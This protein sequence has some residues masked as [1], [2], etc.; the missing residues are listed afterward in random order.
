MP[1]IVAVLG[2]TS[3]G[4]YALSALAQSSAQNLPNVEVQ[5]KRPKPARA[6]K[7]P[8]A[9]PVEEA[10]EHAHR[11]AEPPLSAAPASSTT[12]GSQT[13]EA[14]KPV[15]ND[16]ATL[17]AN[18]PGV[19][20]YQSGG[21][22]SLP[23]IHGLADDRVRTELNGMLITSACGNH[24]N[25]AL[26]YIDPAAVK[27]VKVMAGITPVS[28][29]GDSIGGTILVESAGPVFAAPGEAITYGTAS[30]FARSN[31]GGIAASGSASRPRTTSISPIPAPEPLTITRTAMQQ[32]EVLA[33]EAENH[34]VARRGTSDLLVIQAVYSRSYQGPISAWTCG[35]DGGS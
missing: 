20:L 5:Q 7:K 2:C 10:A 23:A 3:Q 32:G 19:S 21:V 16:T 11:H 4:L 6:V 34:A 28:A 25:P 22:S 8:V 27:Q 35:N 14:A 26:S 15:T 24:M 12:I 31:G 13:I 17:I 30:V 1:K 29:G 33:Y 18:A 9:A